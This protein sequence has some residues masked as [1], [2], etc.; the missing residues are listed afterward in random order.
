MKQTE[1]YH[2]AVADMIKEEFAYLCSKEV[3][4]NDTKISI[5]FIGECS[6]RIGFIAWGR[7]EDGSS[8][9]SVYASP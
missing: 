3:K 6:K 1:I 4:K 8:S 7:E 2:P 5:C 9:G